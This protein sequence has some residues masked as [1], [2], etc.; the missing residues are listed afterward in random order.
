MPVLNTLGANMKSTVSQSAVSRLFLILLLTFFLV[1]PGVLGASRSLNHPLSSDEKIV[2]KISKTIEL[3]AGTDYSLHFDAQNLTLKGQ[4][5]TPYSQG[6][7]DVVLAAIAKSPLWIQ[8]ALTR[9][10]R[11][12]S[13]PES[14]ADLLLNSSKQYTDEIAFSIASCPGGKV[15]SPL[16]LKENT[17]SLYEH[18][19][20]IQ[21]ADIIDYDDGA[22][23]YYSTIQYRVLENGA[24]QHFLLP[25]EIYYWYIVHPKITMEDVD[26]SYG[27][28]WRNYLFEHND[29]GYPL[30][31]E[32]LST[33]KYLW[34]CSSYSQPG[35][36]LWDTWVTLHPTAIEA[37]SYWIGKTVPYPA[38]GDRPGQPCVIAHEHN[39]WCGELQQIAVAAQRAALIPSIGASNVGEDHVWREFYE[40]GWHENDNW[41]SDTGGAVDQPDVYAYGWGKNMSAIYQWRGDDTI[42]DATARYIH[43]QDRVTVNFTIKDSFLQPVDGAR[44]TVLVKGPKDI[45]WYK[46][47]F[48]EKIQGVWDKLPPLLKGKLLTTLFEKFKE[49]YN[50]IPTEVNGVSITTW[51]Y[52]NLQGQCS[53]QL[54]KNREYLFL[55]QQGNLKKP[56]Q[57]ARHNIIRNLNTHE[58]KE[59]RIILADIS[60]R[61]QR[62]TKHELPAG[63]CRF[64]VYFSGSGY[65]RQQNFYT[66]GVGSQNVPGVVDC[67][68]VDTQNFDRYK[69]G[70][71]FTA[72]NYLEAEQATLSMSIQPQEWYLVFRNHGRTT[73]ITLTFSVQVEMSTEKSRVQIVTPDTAVFAVPTFNF[74]DVIPITGIATDTVSLVIG[75]GSYEITPVNGT[76]SYRWN[77]SEAI[78]GRTYH[79]GAT[80]GDAYDS[81][82][83]LLQDTLPPK[84]GIITPA[85]GAIVQY[86]VLNIS[87]YSSDNDYVDHVDVQI[88]NLP[89]VTVIGTTDWTISLSLDGLFIGDHTITAKAVDEHGWESTQ[90]ISFVFNETCHSWG[91]QIN[92]ISCTPLNPTNTSNV[93]V[94]ANVTTTSPFLLKQV[95]LLCNNGSTTTSYE[96]YRYADYPIQSRHEEDP[97][98]NESNAPIFGVELGQFTSG[99][100][101]TY[102]VVAFDTALNKKRSENLSF[103]IE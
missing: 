89:W 48:W 102:W 103:T 9:Q 19:S 47:F 50:A 74:G 16:L 26:A 69:A 24:E 76:W 27:P 67:F 14:Y 29:L 11:N 73:N 63:D 61:P 56:W 13:N 71:S 34:D 57:L 86:D 55:I 81:T 37:V 60:I 36:R 5:I 23:N 65:Q 21:Y 82:T 44:V 46:G 77:T 15:P 49:R 87:G 101:I 43:P 79:V 25:P 3:P 96:M 12:I 70:K 7:S 94:Y 62:I 68:F 4:D 31:K 90:T 2:S 100:T 22:G 84:V 58:D 64:T 10:F 99:E 41:W 97:Y 78:A 80:C 18:D 95:I 72:Y 30:L 8:P 85:A 39:G 66:G 20:W 83:I 28:L 54:G 42:M 17:E 52:T 51:N 45:S 93:I 6:L 75:C 38:V 35:G 59:F 32:K 40:R 33:I 1:S 92:N 88:D 91:P 53:F 98:K